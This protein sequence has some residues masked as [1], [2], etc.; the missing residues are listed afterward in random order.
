ML[1][2]PFS[3]FLYLFLRRVDVCFQNHDPKSNPH[4]NPGDEG[5]QLHV[6]FS[7]NFM[8]LDGV[9]QQ[10]LIRP[11]E[12]MLRQIFIKLGT[13]VDASVKEYNIEPV[14]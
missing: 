11:T 10:Q 14:R 7:S 2:S 13:I 6:S 4:T 12:F 1:M 8:L 5:Y 3:F 9:Q